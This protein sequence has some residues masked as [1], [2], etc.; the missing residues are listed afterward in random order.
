MITNVS[1]D[2]AVLI[3]AVAFFSLIAYAIIHGRIQA[4]K[5]QKGQNKGR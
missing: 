5:N 3:I 2:W 4:R 1:S